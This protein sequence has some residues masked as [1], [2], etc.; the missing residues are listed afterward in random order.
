M[1]LLSREWQ[2]FCSTQTTLGLFK[3]RQNL[4][5]TLLTPHIPNIL[6]LLHPHIPTHLYILPLHTPTFS[7]P[8][9]L[10]LLPP[11]TLTSTHSNP[12]TALPPTS[13]HSSPFTALHLHTL[14]SSHPLF[15]FISFLPPVYLA[16]FFSPLSLFTTSTL[17][18]STK[19]ERVQSF[20]N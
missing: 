19:Y 14:T 17:V 8:Y 20:P 10:I 6:T 13:S 18:I 5:F 9:I 11:H 15:Y 4:Y 12:L 16:M 3:L 7:H 1:T 2:S